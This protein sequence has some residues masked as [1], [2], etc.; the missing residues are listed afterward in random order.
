MKAKELKILRKRLA[1]VNQA[2][3]DVLRNS[4]PQESLTIPIVTSSAEGSSET[5]DSPPSSSSTKT[6]SL[7]YAP[8][9]KISDSQLNEC[10]DLFRTNMAELYEASSWGLDMEEKAHELRHDKAR[11]LLLVNNDTDDDGSKKKL[12]AF[13]HFRFEYDDEDSPTCAVLYVYE[14]QIDG[15]YRRHGIGCRLMRIVEAIAAKEEMSKTVLTVFRTN[16]GAMRFYRKLGYAIDDSN[17]SDADYDIL[18]RAVPPN[19]CA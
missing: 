7:T 5:D 19:D 4:V 17:P 8:S 15:T 2:D 9:R 13:V 1:R 6:L 18:S 10:L 16:Q 12:A 11:F 3:Y 14:I